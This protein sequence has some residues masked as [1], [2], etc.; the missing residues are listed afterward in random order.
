VTIAGA[1]GA[2]INAVTKSGT[3]AFSGSVYGTYRDGDWFGDNPEGVPFNGF[4]SEET[5]GVTFGGPLIK[6]RLFFF[7]NYE[8]FKQTAPGHDLSSTALGKPN[9]MIDDG[10]IARAQQIAQSYGINAGGLES[11]GNTDL[12]EYA[13]KLDWNI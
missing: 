2:N 12:E 1:S 13:I 10:D 6:D 4:T 7:A 11:D 8:K 5:Y 9:P 3:N